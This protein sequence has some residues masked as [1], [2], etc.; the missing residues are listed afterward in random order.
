MRVMLF[1]LLLILASGCAGPGRGGLVLDVTEARSTREYNGRGPHLKTDVSALCRGI[2][3]FNGAP[4]VASQRADASVSQHHASG[5][6]PYSYREDRVNVRQREE[7]RCKWREPDPPPRRRHRSPFYTD[8]YR[9][10]NR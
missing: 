7:A 5:H 2:A 8:S 10:R 6:D 9:Y 3:Y 1:F 4:A